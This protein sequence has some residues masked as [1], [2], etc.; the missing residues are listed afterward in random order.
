MAVGPVL[1]GAPKLN[2]GSEP[3]AA[4][5]LPQR[6]DDT[7]HVAGNGDASGLVGAPLV[8]I[9]GEATYYATCRFCAAASGEL[10]DL[11]GPD[12]QGSFVTVTRGSRHVVVRLTT[13]CGCGPHPA[14]WQPVIDLS[15]QSF[16]RL[17][18]L[19][20][21]HISVV[22]SWESGPSQT[23]PPTDTEETP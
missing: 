3:P 20:A 4:A 21:G 22:V 9:K 23:L 16:A 6:G 13:G 19:S 14:G 12:W 1:L 5:V 18:P 11:I 15:T 8:A 2:T 17:G 10:Q 7:A